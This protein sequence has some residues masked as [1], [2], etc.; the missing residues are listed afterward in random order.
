[1]RRHVGHLLSLSLFKM[2][3]ILYFAV[4][5]CSASQ[6]ALSKL[7]GK[8]GAEPFRFNVYKAGFAFLLFIC[9]F[10]ITER[11]L[12]A[13]TI[14]YGALYGACITVSMHCGYM[15]LSIG[16]MSLTS[17]LATFSLIIPCVYGA[18]FLNETIT[19]FAWL[20]FV[21]LVG[22]LV[23]LN[24]K[25]KK[26]TK[27]PSF[28]WAIYISLTILVN[29]ISSVIQTMQQRDFPGLYRFT[30]MS[31]AM[32]VCVTS[33][34]I[35]CLFKGVLFIRP[36]STDYMGGTSGVLN[37][38]SNFFTLWLAGLSFATLLFPLI[39]ASTML[40]A[41]L[42]GKFFFKEK[43]TKFQIIGFVLGVTSV[44]LLNL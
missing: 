20:G 1:M 41:L 44:I 27:K 40:A 34:A 11:T 25:E 39:S 10:L 36:K 30:F 3:P 4:V 6:S 13:P 7:G 26:D 17:M 21:F 16:P 15:A 14:L 18:V 42:V 8:R 38:L 12:H 33:F 24:I 43:L 37:G 22:A 5:A 29:G 35:L 19:A 9:A 31:A 28:K 2:V 32:L 23:C